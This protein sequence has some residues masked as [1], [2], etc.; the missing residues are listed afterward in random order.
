MESPPTT[1]EWIHEIKFDGYRIQAQLQNGKIRLFTRNGLDWTKKYPLIAERLEKLSL[2]Q[3][4]LDGEMVVLDERGRSDFQ[5]LQAA[6]KEG[7]DE[8]ILY[9]CFDLL[10]LNDKDLRGKPLIERKMEL[11]RLIGK[12]RSPLIR[13][14][15]HLS[16]NAEEF[17]HA[18]CEQQLEGIVSKDKN[19]SY[20]S[21]RTGLWMKTKC[22]KQQEFVIG[23]YTEPRGNRS[24]LGA[25]LLGVYE[26]GNLRYAGRC[27]A[28]FDTVTLKSVY[29]R[30]KPLETK[31][32]P[33]TIDSPHEHDIH[34]VKPK[35]AAEVS[36]SMWTRDQHLRAPVFHGLREDKNMIEIV[37]EKPKLLTKPPLVSL[38]HPDKILYPVEK[39]TK[40]EIADYYSSVSK[41]MLP[42]ISDRPLSLVRCPAGTTSGCF[43]QKHFVPQKRLSPSPLHE[44]GIKESHEVRSYITINSSE[45]LLALVQMGAFEIH[46]WSCHQPDVE[47]P[48]Q[49]VIDLDPAPDVPFSEVKKAARLVKE[50]LEFL[51]LKSF[52]KLSGGKGLH[53]HVPIIPIYSW[54][55][56]KELSKV[57]SE[58]LAQRYPSRFTATMSKSQRKGRIFIDYLRNGRSA[59]AVAPYSLR[60]KKL[61][62]VAMPIEWKELSTIDRADHFTLRK[63]LEHLKKRKKDPWKLYQTLPQRIS[64][65]EPEN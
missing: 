36:F 54:N 9:Y 21:G 31:H 42:Q 47:H 65:L 26:N 28:G 57:V 48:D 14:S 30:L 33:F 56:I 32:S 55:E 10:Y 37:K 45:G 51:N 4:I 43:Y 24:S 60:A 46:T 3:C 17:F 18:S 49:I 12:I 2:D 13:F 40:Q 38:T 53:I 6:M 41:F 22:Q 35:L 15:D 1:G 39:I 62:S 52:V 64:I 29:R 5:A 19:A 58:A 11:K 50:A 7:R 23:G 25:L 44:I 16:K 27:G 59:T 8:S 20:V 63:A 61:S 34:W